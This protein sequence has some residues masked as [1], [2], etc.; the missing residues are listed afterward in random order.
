V[1]G[2]AI[3]LLFSGYSLWDTSLKAADLRAFVP[4]VIQF[5]A[6]YHNS[7][8]EVIAVPIT[9]TNEGAPL[10]ESALHGPVHHRHA[11][12]ADQALLCGG[13]RPLDHGD[14]A[15]APTTP[16]RPSRFPGA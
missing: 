16:L 14:D 5:P 2:S 13:L 1:G 8:F 3:A 12:Q 4:P 6:P 9:L 10:G 15:R 11:H 7:N